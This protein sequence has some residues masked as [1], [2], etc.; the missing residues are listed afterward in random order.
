MRRA[1]QEKAEA[2]RAA[3]VA[4]SQQREA[5]VQ[6][7][8]E[9]ADRETRVALQE[10]ALVAHRQALVAVLGVVPFPIRDG[11]RALASSFGDDARGTATALEAVQAVSEA[12]TAYIS[13]GSPFNDFELLLTSAASRIKLELS[14]FY[15][16]GWLKIF[17]DELA[18]AHERGAN[19]REAQ[20][21]M[22]AARASLSLESGKLSS[23]ATVPLPSRSASYAAFG[24]H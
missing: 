16:Q 17:E 20:E 12:Y 14:S 15:P 22:R 18:L 2:L 10:A 21:R 7:A 11:V 19:S 1:A 5:A 3:D 13:E 6:A 9:Q 24:F 8:K 23:A 4:A